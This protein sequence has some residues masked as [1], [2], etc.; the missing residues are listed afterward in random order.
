MKHVSIR[1]YGRVQGVFFRA[2]AKEEADELGIFGS[3]RNEYDGSVAIEAEGDDESIRKFIE[4]C[5]K[6]PKLA[7]VERCDVAEEA[8]QNIRGFSI[9]R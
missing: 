7:R 1:V 6:G 3:V 2:S 9:A 5:K 4:W 8:V